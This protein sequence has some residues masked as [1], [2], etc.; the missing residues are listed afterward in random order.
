MEKGYCGSF[1]FIEKVIIDKQ[2][3]VDRSSV[4]DQMAVVFILY[5]GITFQVILIDTGSVATT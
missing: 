5:T 1:L 4:N 3:Q 2:Q